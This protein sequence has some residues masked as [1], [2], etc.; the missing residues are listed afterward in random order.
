M[1]LKVILIFFSLVALDSFV[2]IKIAQAE[3]AIRE[4]HNYLNNR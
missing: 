2:S 1:K 4:T 3:D